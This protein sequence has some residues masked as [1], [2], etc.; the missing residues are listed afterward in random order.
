MNILRFDEA[1]L[2]K[3]I[4]RLAPRL[5]VAFAASCAE[6]LRPA[7][8]AFS[9]RSGGGNPGKF[10]AILDHLWRDLDRPTMADDE[11]GARIASCMGLIPQ[12]DDGPW[13]S[14]QASAEDA[15]AALAYA[16]QCLQS[17]ESQEAAW[18]ARR[19]YEA[20]DHYV[21]AHENVDMKAPGAETKVL[22]HPLVQ[23][24]LGRQRRDIRELLT[25]KEQDITATINRLRHRA[26]TEATV[27]F[28]PMS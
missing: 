19:A 22:S 5:R 20:L 10:E 8:L 17:G 25:A 21:I 12:E 15:G 9:A 7:Y 26:R 2:I 23:A 6:R 1:H 14:E 3:D 4:D 24:E 16:L 28:G 27:F 11:I 13:L 18:A